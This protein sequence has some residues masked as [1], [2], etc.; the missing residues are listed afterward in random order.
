MLLFLI[1]F[2]GSYAGLLSVAANK[3]TRRY[4]KKVQPV[5]IDWWS[6]PVPPLHN[7]DVHNYYLLMNICLIVLCFNY[8]VWV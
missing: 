8:G 1:D 2:Y 3:K 7:N 6:T 5:N 4:T